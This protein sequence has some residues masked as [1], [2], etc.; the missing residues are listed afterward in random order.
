MKSLNC[1]HADIA[2]VVYHMFKDDFVYSKKKTWYQFYNHKWNKIDEC[3]PLKVKISTD[4]V[5]KYWNIHTSTSAK[6]QAMEEGDPA[7]ELEIER[8]AQIL[9]RRKK[10]QITDEITEKVIN[11]L[12]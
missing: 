8:L 4:V 12:N 2:S 3:I 10:T 5:D 6:A 9:S 11:Q 7:K 1:S